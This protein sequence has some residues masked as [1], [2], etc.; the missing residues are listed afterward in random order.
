MLHIADDLLSLPNLSEYTVS[1]S[2]SAVTTS[3]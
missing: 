1:D 3:Q 2:A